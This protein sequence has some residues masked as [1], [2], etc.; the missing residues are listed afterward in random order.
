[1]FVSNTFES[2]VYQTFSTLLLVLHRLEMN[3]G[4]GANELHRLRF[5]E[6]RIL[7]VPTGPLYKEPT[8]P[9]TIL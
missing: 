9:Y 7:L 2:W 1:M 6:A 4:H 5:D 3:R 8:D